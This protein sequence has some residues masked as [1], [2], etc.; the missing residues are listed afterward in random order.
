MPVKTW[1]SSVLAKVNMGSGTPTL[2]C[3][4]TVGVP[5][6][7][8]IFGDRQRELVRLTA[9]CK[10]IVGSSAELRQNFVGIVTN[11]RESVDSW[12]QWAR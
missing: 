1:Y 10:G 6:R 9:I 8:T 3:T 12:C 2:A 4:M 11:L 5:A 7:T